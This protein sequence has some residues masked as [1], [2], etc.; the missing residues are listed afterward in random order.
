VQDRSR[1]DVVAVRPDGQRADVH[2]QH[3]HGGRAG[4]AD[5]DTPFACGNL[6]LLI[7]HKG[8]TIPWHREFSQS[9]QY[10]AFTPG[11]DPDQVLCL[12][13]AE[14]GSP[15]ERALRLLAGE[16]YVRAD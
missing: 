12:H 13:V 11:G 8:S 6:R 1:P 4:R 9:L 5:E 7:G 15:S 3:H 10:E 16:P 2:R 14:P